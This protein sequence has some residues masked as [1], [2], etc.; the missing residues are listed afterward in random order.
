[1]LH[2]HPSTLTGILKRLEARGLVIRR[3]DGRDA[4]RSLLALSDKGKQLDVES[5]GT[6]EATV[7]SAIA[8]LPAAQGE[9]VRGA[10]QNLAQALARNADRP[11]PANPVVARRAPRRKRGA[12][13][14]A[15]R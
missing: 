5:E 15:P 6:I 3:T 2:I 13:K 4:R 12:Q 14:G 8:E 9:V 1:V 11:P 10:L 7:Q